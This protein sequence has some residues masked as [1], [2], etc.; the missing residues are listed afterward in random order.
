[1]LLGNFISDGIPFFDAIQEMDEQFKKAKDARREITSTVIRRMRGGE[2]EKNFFTLGQALSGIVPSTEAMT[3]DA[4][5]QAADLAGGLRRAAALS[6]NASRI[7]KTIRSE[8]T[9][10]IFLLA[11]LLVLLFMVSTSV[12]PVLGEIAPREHWPIHARAL[13]A[14][15]DKT[16]WI[17]GGILFLVLGIGGWFAASKGRWTGEM[18]N[19]FD[20]YVFPWNLNRRITGAMFMSSVSALLRMGMPLSQALDRLSEISS[21]WE[22]KH[23]AAIKSR[24]RKG[25]REGEAIAGPLFDADI[26]WQI[27]LYGRL[28]DFSGGLERMAERVTERVIDQTAKSFGFFRI[29]MLIGVAG[30]IVWVYSSFLAVTMA[31]RTTGI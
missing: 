17:A 23:F 26:R 15:A 7:R 13:G 29:L 31:A 30:M 4:G 8:L 6:Q 25:M 16:V 20:R 21:A 24:M 2:K 5:E 1:M 3:I 18:R 10:P 12:L 9:Y 19:I 14:V 11:L 22:R 28:T 27:I